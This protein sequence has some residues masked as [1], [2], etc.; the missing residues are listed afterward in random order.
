MVDTSKAEALQGMTLPQELLWLATRAQGRKTIVEVGSWKGRSTRAIADNMRPDGLLFAVDTWAGSLGPNATAAER[1][2]YERALAGKP[3]SWLKDQF[4]NNMAGVG[5]LVV[6]QMTSVEGAA[7]LHRLRFDMIFI[8]AAHDYESM[9]KDIL[10]WRPLL[11]EDGLFCGHDY[12][13]YK[14]RFPGVDQAVDEL[15]SNPKCFPFGEGSLWW[16]EKQ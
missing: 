4:L 7:T 6:L 14:G 12:H 11:S 15:I 16:E 3:E 9:R 1:A 13:D 5:N 2:V 10:A 8:D